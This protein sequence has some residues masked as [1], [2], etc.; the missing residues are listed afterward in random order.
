MGGAR[1]VRLGID[2]DVAKET[3]E[4]CIV[5]VRTLPAPAAVVNICDG[6]TARNPSPKDPKTPNSIKYNKHCVSKFSAFKAVQ[7]IA[8]LIE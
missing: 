2:L 4:Q 3:S 7:I 6:G 8:S 5:H 1:L